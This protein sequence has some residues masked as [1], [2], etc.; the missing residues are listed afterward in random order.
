R[1]L[2]GCI[3]RTKSDFS[4]GASASP[5]RTSP[6][7]SNGVQAK[8]PR[9]TARRGPHSPAGPSKLVKQSHIRG[10]AR[11][12]NILGVAR[13]R[14]IFVRII[15]RIVAKSVHRLAGTVLGN[16][17]HVPAQIVLEPPLF[18][19]FAPNVPGQRG[20]SRSLPM[21][22]RANSTLCTSTIF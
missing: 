10:V 8:T 6:C 21:A 20:R 11:P 18:R 22:R 1:T 7:F 17:E 16:H 14:N 19:V 4:C 15:S 13:L 3:Q 12:S 5:Q 2:S 9:G